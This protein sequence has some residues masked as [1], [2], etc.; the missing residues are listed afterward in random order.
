MRTDGGSTGRRPAGAPGAPAGAV[1]AEPRGLVRAAGAALALAVTMLALALAASPAGAQI[2]YAHGGDLWVMND[3]GSGQRPLLT[4][5][6][7]SGAAIDYNN[8]GDQPVSVQPGGTGVAFVAPPAGSCG[9]STSNC[10]GIYTLVGGT[11]RRL[12]AASAPC[13]G[14][15]VICSSEEEGPAVTADGRVVYQRL[16]VASS[17]TCVYYCGYGGGY[18]EAYY[19]R[20]LDG[21][22]APLAWPVPP[23]AQGQRDNAGVDPVFEGPLASDPA[24]AGVLAYMGNYF[25]V[26]QGPS[27]S[28][29]YYPL[30][31]DQSSTS[32]ATVNQPSFDDSYLYGLA[33]SPDGSLLADVETGDHKGIWVYP[34]GQSWTAGAAGS[35][36]WALQ[37]PDDNDGQQ[38]DHYIT[39]VTFAGS[40][41]LV[42]SANYNLYEIP[43]R[44]WATPTTANPPVANCHFPQDATQLT[45]DGT[46]AAPDMSPAWTSSTTPV[47]AYSPPGSG[48]GTG[49]GTTG[50]GQ[51]GSGN[52][53]NAGAPNTRLLHDQ[54]DR[55]HH[56]A[57]FSFSARG[58]ATSFQ[59]ALVKQPKHRGRHHGAA[60]PAYHRCRSPKTY[61]HLARG[62]YWF[63]VRA[64]GA[65]G[66]D[67][68]PA[69][70]RFSL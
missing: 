68:S 36:T 66:T 1:Q 61:S 70:V 39:G 58:H 64:V 4:A 44:C 13:G 43:A 12:T 10:P 35:Y 69:S 26:G 51:T 53:S 15:G 37:D 19:V 7:N 18:Q 54:I 24:D 42:F 32:P 50:G 52:G 45:H 57:K 31:I 28:G 6:Q 27:S 34:A 59:C 3:D 49:G 25:G 21:S 47:P 55:R 60:R 9:S 29:T 2:V 56:R 14:G 62:A 38:L 5:A 63:Y 67:R 65:G 11:V 33:F 41:E 46:Q 48:G 22:D 8:G 16:D 30:D 17:F 40:S 20:K 23:V